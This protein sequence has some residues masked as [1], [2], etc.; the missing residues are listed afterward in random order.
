[1]PRKRIVRNP[2]GA[3]GYV[4][5]QEKLEQREKAFVIYRDMGD[6]RT[7]GKLEKVLKAKHPELAASQ[8]AVRRWSRMHDWSARCEAHDDAKKNTTHRL[9]PPVVA[10]DGS[11]NQIDALLQAANQALTRAMTATPVVSRPGDVKSLVDA[12]GNALKLIETI[13]NQSTGKV[14]RED[15]AQE[16]ARV[17]DL[18]RKARELDVE[19]MVEA[20]L[21][22]LGVSRQV[23]G[24]AHGEAKEKVNVE[25]IAVDAG[26]VDAAVDTPAVECA[27]DQTGLV[28]D[29][30]P[31][32]MRLFA[33]VLKAFQEGG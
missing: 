10:F 13:K 17:L 18:V 27:G 15:V 25:P 22:K 30:K 28:G 26:D 33:D 12:A 6:A 7:L 4:L 8:A 9:N 19:V 16:M 31:V 11:F 32:G 24:A 1:M 3:N 14:S 5:P 29:G 21:K 20:E 2:S 23:D